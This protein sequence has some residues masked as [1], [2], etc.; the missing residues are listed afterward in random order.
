[1]I[2]LISLRKHLHRYPELSNQE[3]GTADHITGFIEQFSPDRVIPVAGTGRVFVFESGKPGPTVMFRAE[4]D[5]LPVTE[6]SNADHISQH[7]GVAHVCGHDGHMAILAGL[8]GKIAGDRPPRGKAVLLFQ[9]AEEVEQGAAAVIRDPRFREI[10]PDWI[11]A[12]H[13][14]PGA[15]MHRVIIKAGSFAAASRGM[16]VRLSGRTSHA[17]EPEK[18]INPA[19]AVARII[20]SMKEMNDNPGM[21]GDVTFSTV[22]HIL[23]GEISFGTSAGHAE[24]RFTLRAFG[25]S[26]MEILT[27]RAEKIV[28]ETAREEQLGHEISYGE[29]FPATVND[30]ACA[31]LIRLAAS[32]NQLPVEEAGK[33]FRWSEDFGYYTEKYRCGFFGLGSGREQPALHNPD[34]DFPDELIGT[35]VN[36]FYSIYKMIVHQ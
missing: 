11:F 14:I 26:D 7:P 9:P 1:M 15:A 30:E 12:L 34:F 8:A 21:F 33:P 36:L 25:D 6:V 19:V 32:A 4:L 20:S 13:N 27:T 5:A 22:I 3:F 23:L 17:G 35:G 29:I 24:M 31:E 16:T 18:G 28:A 2:E 10:E